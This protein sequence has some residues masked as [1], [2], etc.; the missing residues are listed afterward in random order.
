[1]LFS[2]LSRPTSKLVAGSTFSRITASDTAKPIYAVRPITC[3]TKLYKEDKRTPRVAERALEAHDDHEG[4]FS[5]TDNTVQI[6]HPEEHEHPPSKPIQGRGGMHFKRTLANFTLDGKVAVV[7]GGARGLGLVMSQACLLSGANIALVD[8]NSKVLT[9]DQSCRANPISAEDEGARQA[10][11]L[12]RH[13]REE[14]P[15]VDE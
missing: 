3:T 8:L 13:F 10:E 5:R 7:T 4:S 2:R 1:M 14:N 15:G 9:C 12:V 6:Y 11:E